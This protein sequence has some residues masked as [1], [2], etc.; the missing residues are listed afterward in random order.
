MRA[1]WWSERIDV[2]GEYQT[3]DFPVHTYP[4]LRYVT[5]V[6]DTPLHEKSLR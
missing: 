4:D 6:I 3:L 5:K 1:R 2:P